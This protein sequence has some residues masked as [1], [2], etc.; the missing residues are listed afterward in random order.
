[1]HLNALQLHK[2]A[3]LWWFMIP[4]N[5]ELLWQEIQR[6]K[7]IGVKI[8]TKTYK[9]LFEMCCVEMCRWVHTGDK[10][11][12]NKVILTLIVWLTNNPLHSR[13]KAANQND[14]SST[15]S[16]P[17]N[18]CGVCGEIWPWW[19]LMLWCLWWV[20][21]WWSREWVFV[22]GSVGAPKGPLQLP[23]PDYQWYR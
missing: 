13:D 11:L 6:I 23:R 14:G 16:R 8:L 10:T 15:F 3:S 22:C 18:P 20:W 4:L 5:T 21:P 9:Y 19:V 17:T 12:W 7:G 1:M 2:I